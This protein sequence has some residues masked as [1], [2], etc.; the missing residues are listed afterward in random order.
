MKCYQFTIGEEWGTYFILCN[1]FAIL[2]VN[3]YNT[4]QKTAHL[5]Y[6]ISIT[7]LY[8][9]TSEEENFCHFLSSSNR[10]IYCCSSMRKVNACYSVSSEKLFPYSTVSAT[11]EKYVTLHLI[12]I[13]MKKIS[14]ISTFYLR[15]SSFI[16]KHSLHAIYNLASFKVD[17]MKILT[18]WPAGGLNSKFSYSHING[19]PLAKGDCSAAEGMQP[20]RLR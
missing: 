17:W 14:F 13:K 9:I 15:D 8:N 7:Y 11:P 20:R 16:S 19:S 18:N 5:V 12:F 2:F 3:A 10:T 4:R 1:I 6:F